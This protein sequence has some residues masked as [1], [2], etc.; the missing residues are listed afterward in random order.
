MPLHLIHEARKVD[1]PEKLEANA[2]IRNAN[3]IWG[4]FA[5]MD[6]ITSKQRSAIMSRI[7][8][9]NTRPEI[10]V[11][12]LLW[13]MGCRY[14]L[15]AKD[16]PGKPDIVFRSRKVA[17]YVHG[18]FW[19]SCPRPG[20]KKTHVPKSNS[21]Y[22]TAKLKRNQERDAANLQALRA[23]GFRTLVVWECETETPESLMAQLRS[24]FGAQLRSF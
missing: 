9:K 24:F 17:I 1:R 21:E 16:L 6:K 5:T 15:H 11:R 19:H 23:L 22:W 4:V 18:C 2:A 8:S 12:R 7:K 20:C 3:T 13:G 14:R 10:I